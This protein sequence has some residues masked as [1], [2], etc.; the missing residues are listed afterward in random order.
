V[1]LVRNCTEDAPR[2]PFGLETIRRVFAQHK[3]VVNQTF[4]LESTPP[5]SSVRSA[6]SSSTAGSASAQTESERVLG[7]RRTPQGAWY[8]SFVVQH[9]K[10]ALSKFLKSLPFSTPPFLRAASVSHSDAAWVFFGRNPGQRPL[11]GR[12]EHTDAIAHSGTWH[13]QLRGCKVWILRPTAELKK[14]AK[15]LRGVGHVRVRCKEGD[16]LCVNTRLWWHQTYIPSSCGL[17][18]SVARDIWLDARQPTECDMTNIEGSYATQSIKR[19]TVVFTEDDMPDLSLPRSRDSNCSVRELDGT[20][21]VVAKRKIAAG[22]WFSVS[23]S[24][25]E[26]EDTVAPQSGGAHGR[27]RPRRT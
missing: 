16:V 24:E 14:R 26:E 2:K 19:G 13:L 1:V 21:V 5:R 9:S 25:A 7:R 3:K 18:V 20:M 15:C 10:A 4:C 12:P 27:K 23:D 11:Q 8:A 22:D 6:S 17:S